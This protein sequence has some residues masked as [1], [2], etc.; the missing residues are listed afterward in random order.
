LD[1]DFV[2]PVSPKYA[3]YL[4]EKGCLKK[5]YNYLSRP[6]ETKVYDINK[7]IAMSA[8][9]QVLAKETSDLS[10]FGVGC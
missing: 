5:E 2:F 1:S 6:T 10:H 7:K 8:V 9:R 4:G 3:I